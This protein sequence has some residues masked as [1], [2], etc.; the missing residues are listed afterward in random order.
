MRLRHALALGV[1]AA[2]TGTA[3]LALAVGPSSAAPADPAPNPG[4]GDKA[5]S[6]PNRP[7]QPPASAP[8]RAAPN[9]P[10]P[11]RAAQL[12]ASAP[13]RAAPNL[14][15]RLPA[16]GEAADPDFPIDTRI[17]GGP[18]AY[19]PGAGFRTFAVDLTNTT[20]EPCGGIHPVLALADRDRVLRPAQIRMDFYDSEARRWRPVT[21]EETE[22]D[23]NVGV[24][25]DVAD[26]AELSGLSGLSR[27][28]VGTEFAGFDV[29]AGRTVT[30]PVRLAFR[31][32]TAANEVVANAA[33]VQRQGDDGDWVGES[34]DYRLTI[35]AEGA[36]EDPDSAPVE[37]TPPRG[38]TGLPRPPDPARPELGRTGP[39]LA[40]TG[41]ESAVLLAPASGALVLTGAGLLVAARRRHRNRGRRPTH[42][43]DAPIR[44]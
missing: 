16:C 17:H 39:E 6:A 18:P 1:T 37:A 29:A 31:E 10:A 32:G 5:N 3:V 13:N 19:V 2:T 27:D 44:P 8:D 22:E 28:A 26:L 7:A 35:V 41:P 38:D 20:A 40:R 43:P 4:P 12:P 25:S 36:E 9:R 42:V 15:A 23:E 21:F 11:N 30:V 33:I 14:P 24:F 34:D